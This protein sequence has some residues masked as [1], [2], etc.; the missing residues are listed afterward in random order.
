MTLTQ[1]LNK[2]DSTREILHRRYGKHLDVNKLTALIARL[3]E[4]FNINLEKEV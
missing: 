1:W 2:V 4:D 3:T